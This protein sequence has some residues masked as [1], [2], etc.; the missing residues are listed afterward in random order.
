VWVRF[1]G[2][3]SFGVGLFGLLSQDKKNKKCIYL[4]ASKSVAR[5]FRI[6]DQN[7]VKFYCSSLILGGTGRFS[8]NKTSK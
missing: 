1:L 6:V 3:N 2:L 5:K 7:W 8:P 4:A